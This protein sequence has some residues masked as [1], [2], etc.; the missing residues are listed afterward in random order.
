MEESKQEKFAAK[1]E[2]VL[3]VIGCPY[4]THFSGMHIPKFMKYACVK[5]PRRTDVL[6]LVLV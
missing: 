1:E 4:T 5:P 2:A 6:K 3:S